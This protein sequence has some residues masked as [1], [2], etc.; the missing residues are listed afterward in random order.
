MKTPQNVFVAMLLA[1]SPAENFIDDS[2]GRLTSLEAH[3]DLLWR[4]FL[5]VVKVQLCQIL[6]AQ[7]QENGS[8]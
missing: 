8:T 6:W 3:E 2:I 4:T 7:P 5:Y 1:D